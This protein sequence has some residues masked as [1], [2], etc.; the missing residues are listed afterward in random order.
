MSRV[1]NRRIRLLL[2]V[3]AAAFGALFLRAAWLQAVRAQSL[4]RLGETQHREEV[5]IPASRGTIYD[6][7]GVQLALGEQATTVIAD[8]MQIRDPAHDA[9]VAA[10]I[11][12][13]DAKRLAAT[14]ADRRLGFVYVKR[15]ADP[16][17]AS[18][19]AKRNLT[20]FDFYPE[21]RRAYPQH[22]VAAQVLG[23]A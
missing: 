15:K 5:T 10:R 2:F 20:G 8:P 18:A 4:S 13:L 22:S 11:L 23:F 1:V 7:M 3:L 6:R 16:A 12:G 17:K 21:E 19:L 14:L 9:A